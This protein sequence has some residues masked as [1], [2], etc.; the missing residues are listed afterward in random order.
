MKRVKMCAILVLTVVFTA[1]AAPAK[2]PVR[3]GVVLS[4]AGMMDG[5]EISEVVLTILALEKAKAN[6]IFMAPNVNQ[7]K[8]VN[9]MTNADA[10]EQRN[11]L[12][13]SARISRGNVKDIKDVKSADLDAI[14]LVGGLGS[15]LNLSDFMAKGADCTVN[16]D[17][18]RLVTELNAS[19]KPVGSMCLA[20]ANLGKILGSK[21][22]VVTIGGNGSDFVKSLTAM[23]AVN[24]EC[25]ATDIIFD[26][27][28]LVV[29]TPAMMV[30]AS[31]PDLATGIEKMINKVIELTG[32]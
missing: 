24:K 4:G 20:S 11:V 29:T 19:K 3:V 13:E 27:A 15:V 26:Q 32:K 12:V 5:S 10:A 23:G 28:N 30:G 7:A 8:V 9:H 25:A 1:F 2:S 17:L 21:K 22:V 6:I 18:S 31:T 16:A 14:V